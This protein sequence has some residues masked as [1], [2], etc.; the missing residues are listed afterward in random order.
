MIEGGLSD[1]MIRLSVGL[2]DIND[3]M[4]DFE[5]ASGPQPEVSVIMLVLGAPR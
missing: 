2:E 5:K 1:D 4:A 3:I